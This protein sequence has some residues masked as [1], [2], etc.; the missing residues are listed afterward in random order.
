MAERSAIE[1]ALHRGH[2][3]RGLAGTCD[4]V[5]QVGAKAASRELLRDRL[6]CLLLLRIQRERLRGFNP[7]R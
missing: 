2:V 1:R 5:E 4:A 6:K 7:L 3:H